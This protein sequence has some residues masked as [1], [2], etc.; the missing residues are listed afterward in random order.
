LGELLLR[1]AELLVF[2]HPKPDERWD[3]LA[4]LAVQF[5]PVYEIDSPSDPFT[6][7]M[8]IYIMLT[9][10]IPRLAVKA[11]LKFDVAAEF[12]KASGF[13]LQVFM[14]FMFAVLM[15]ALANVS[16]TRARA[17]A[18]VA[19]VMPRFDKLGRMNCA[20]R[21]VGVVGATRVDESRL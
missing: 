12:E 18:R 11:K 15:H 3:A 6:Q 2:L 4:N 14:D 7:L 20:R 5:V 13:S 1:A 21:L 9:V 19:C 16:A 10:N 8:R 17:I